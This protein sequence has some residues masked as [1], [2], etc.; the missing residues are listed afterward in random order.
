VFTPWRSDHNPAKAKDGELSAP[1][2][3][4]LLC[5]N[6]AHC[7]F[8]NSAQAEAA[9]SDRSE[10]FKFVAQRRRRRLICGGI[11]KPGA[12]TNRGERIVWWC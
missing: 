8:A 4:P 9:P 1:G 7:K 2:G 3:R 6:A 12:D 10:S 5:R 11:W